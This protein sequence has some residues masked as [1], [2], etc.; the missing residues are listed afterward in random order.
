MP[1]RS[2]IVRFL[3]QART[4][5]WFIVVYALLFTALFNVPFWRLLF[6]RLGG[7]SLTS[8]QVMVSLAVGMTALH[9]IVLLMI[10]SRWLFKPLTTV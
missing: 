3:Q 2:P 4:I 9:V 1:L 6:A 8:T 10:S 5:E 7:W